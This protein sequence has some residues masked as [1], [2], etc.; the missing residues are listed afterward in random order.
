M[1]CPG[2][3]GFR[4]FRLF[5]DAGE[6]SHS[7]PSY[8]LFHWLCAC[9][10]FSFHVFYFMC[11]VF[12]CLYHAWPTLRGRWT[13]DYC[14]VYTCPTTTSDLLV[15]CFLLTHVYHLTSRVLSPDHLTYYYL[16]RPSWYDLT[17]PDYYQSLDITYH[18]IIINLLYVWL[19]IHYHHPIML[20]P[21]TQ[22]DNLTCDYYL[23]GNL[24]LL[25]CIMISDLFP[26]LH[27]VT[28]L[29]STYVLLISWS[30]LIP[31]YS[32]KVIIKLLNLKMDQLVLGR[33]KHA[34]ID[35]CSCLQ[36][37]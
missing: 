24:T 32:R 15:A 28:W 11:Y 17:Y 5:G 9:S 8:F 20:S 3:R 33:G 31:D 2:F 35:M 29:Y 7:L 30:C 19:L 21:Y 6:C 18:L 16:A 26:A 4:T 10:S 37:H 36:W 22:H 1:A 27:A 14:Y 34:D 23:Y 13:L 25:S 12:Y